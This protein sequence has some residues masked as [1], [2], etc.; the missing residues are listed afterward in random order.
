MAHVRSSGLKAEAEGNLHLL[1][2][3]EILFLLGTQG[4]KE[5]KETEGRDKPWMEE[6]TVAFHPN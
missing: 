1:P 5:R 2:S 4:R 3:G 6:N